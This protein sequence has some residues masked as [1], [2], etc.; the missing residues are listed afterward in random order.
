MS[1]TDSTQRPVRILFVCL[2][3]TCRSVMAEGLARKK[4]GDTIVVTSAGICPQKAEHAKMAINTLKLFKVDMS[5]HMPRD[6]KTVDITSFDH[7]IALDKNIAKKLLDIP[8]DKLLTWNISDPWGY[9][10]SKYE[11]CAIAIKREIS[12]LK[13]KIDVIQ[14]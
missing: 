10:D 2:G 4:F 7:V 3:N 14:K 13:D 9:D 1:S 8:V 6:V 11:G 12:K 5:S